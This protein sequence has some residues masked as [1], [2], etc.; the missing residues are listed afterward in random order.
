M[1]AA[2]T[3]LATTGSLRQM[4]A[5]ST[6]HA[7]ISSFLDALSPEDK[8]RQVLAVKGSWVGK[9]YD[10]VAGAPQVTLDDFV[11]R[12]HEGTLVYQGRNSLPLFTRFQKRFQRLPGA[13]GESVVVGYNEQL[14]RFFTGPGYFVVRDGD[15]A[16]PHGD[17]L[18]F[19]YTAVP[20]GVPAGWPRYKSNES[21]FSR[22]VYMGMKDY[23]R[24]VARGVVVGKAYKLGVDRKAFF[25]LTCTE[26]A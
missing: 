23:C 16:G 21:G 25:S 12:S 20:P 3:A 4:L 13:A 8:L 9:L 18:L 7:E 10:A 14:F 2:T 24:R 5:G 6:S 11:P 19:D 22:A 15:G 1:T 26:L 17:E